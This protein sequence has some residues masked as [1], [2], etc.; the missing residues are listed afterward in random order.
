[1]NPADWIRLAITWTTAGLATVA[2]IQARRGARQA[3]ARL[4]E[5]RKRSA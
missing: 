2:A 4:E 3:R 5:L 1:M